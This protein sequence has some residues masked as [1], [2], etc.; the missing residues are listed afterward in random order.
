[1][2]RPAALL[3]ALL[4]CLGLL[5]LAPAAGAADAAPREQIVAGL[6]ENQIAIT[7]SFSGSSILV[8]GAV[9][10]EAP[11]AEPPLQVIITL[12]G[13]RTP[14]LVSRKGHVF[15][16]W[17]NTANVRITQA[18]AY[19]AIATSAP[20]S[21]IL[22]Q[23]D[24]LR[25]KITIPRAIRETGVASQASDPHT[26]IDALIRLREKNGLYAVNEGAVTIEQS[27]LFRTR[28]KLPANLTEGLYTARIFLTRNGHVVATQK[29]DI[30]V[31]KIGVE[32]WLFQLAQHQPA[33][34]GLLS[35]VIAIAA[36]WLA[37]AV[38][39]LARR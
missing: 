18:P 32:R 36:G 13:P 7:A 29:T 39:R 16:L 2:S 35:L 34:Y 33:V 37:S 30:R 38:F 10:R 3:A 20:L 22:S 15:G 26:F 17:I 23:T 5:A 12:Q 14:V 25:Y 28:L 21:K 8:F 11:P 19:Y 31:R 4:A 1:M 6:S 24:D 9:K 27:T